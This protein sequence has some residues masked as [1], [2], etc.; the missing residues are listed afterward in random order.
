MPTNRHSTNFARLTRAQ[1]TVDLTLALQRLP[2]TFP[3]IRSMYPRVTE[4][5]VWRMLADI[6][7]VTELTIDRCGRYSVPVI[8]YDNGEERRVR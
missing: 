6:R 2:R 8:F 5:T 3:Q 4:R 7:D 1:R